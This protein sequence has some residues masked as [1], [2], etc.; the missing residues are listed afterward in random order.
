MEP[1]LRSRRC[2]PPL[3]P[4]A[5]PR[6]GQFSRDKT[7]VMMRT[8]GPRWFLPLVFLAVG[9]AGALWACNIP[10]FR[11]AM[12]HWEAD[13][14]EAVV[15]HE[16]PLGQEHQAWLDQLRAAADDPRRP[17][18][19][20]VTA[21]DLAELDDQD[22]QAWQQRV[23]T[24]E[25]P[26]VQLRFPRVS[27][28]DQQIIAGPLDD[29]W[30]EGVLDSPARRE[31]VDRLADGDSA[32]WVLLSSGDAQ[33]DAK[34][35]KLMQEYFDRLAEPG[36]PTAAS[37]AGELSLFFD[38]DPRAAQPN[39]STGGDPASGDQEPPRFTLLRVDR[40]DP[41]ERVFVSMLLATEDDLHEFDAPITLPV[42]GRGRAFYALVGDGITENNLREITE[43]LL[44]DCSCEVKAGNPGADL[45]F[46]ADWQSMVSENALEEREFPS[47]LG[48]GA[49]E[50]AEAT[51]ASARSVG[52]ASQADASSAPKASDESIRAG[53]GAAAGEKEAEE[54]VR[55]QAGGGDLDTIV[56]VPLGV[57]VAGALLALLAVVAVGTVVL[58][59]RGDAG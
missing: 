14:Y 37:P 26:W 15:L 38:D 49:F 48:P 17:A 4:R 19:L 41:Q 47:L 22:R 12:D 6:N 20:E 53:R 30:G 8:L 33:A 39:P 50:L 52:S 36:A 51:P 5:P 18:N 23:G 27:G 16:G 40:D 44:G 10:V 55:V 28:I 56:M 7:M 9:S 2:L 11:Y 29:S 25:L 59:R 54:E 42:F 35:E 31:I 46:A 3:L 43:F 24:T 13:P 34:A 32:V 57:A 58:T 1:P 21:I 45:L